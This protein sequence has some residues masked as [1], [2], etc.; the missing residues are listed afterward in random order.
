MLRKLLF[1]GLLATAALPAVASTLNYAFRAVP[2]RTGIVLV[3]S[4]QSGAP[5]NFANDA[6]HVFY[7]LDSNR[8]IKPGGWSFYN[9]GAPSRV[10]LEI[11]NRW[12]A[13]SGILLPIDEVITK[14]SAPY[15][16]LNL[17]QAGEAQMSNYDLLLVPAYRYVSLNSLEREKLRRFVE[18]GG[19]LWVDLASGSGLTVDVLNGFPLPFNASTTNLGLANSYEFLHP[20]FNRPNT[21]TTADIYNMESEHLLGLRNVDLLALGLGDLREHHSAT[22]YDSNLFRAVAEDELGPQIGVAQIGEGY[23]IVTSRGLSRSINQVVDPA[24]GTFSSNL[25]PYGLKPNFSRSA[26]AAAKLV[27]NMVYLSSSYSQIG[28]G[29]RKTNSSILDLGAPML[30]SWDA[31]FATTPGSFNYIPPAIYKGRTYAVSNG[32]LFCLDSKP[33][34]DLDKDGN[35]DDGVLDFAFGAN[36]D[37]IWQQNIVGP[38]SPPTCAEV[39]GSGSPDQVSIID[40]TGRMVVFDAL[41]GANLATINPPAAAEVEPGLPGR[42][43]YSPTYHDG[44]YLISDQVNT[45]LSSVGRV[46]IVD[47]ATLAPLTSTGPW[48]CGG[49]SSQIMGKPT[50]SPTVG[51]IPV[52]D[53][54]GALD[55][56]VYVPTRPAAFGG[57]NANAAVHSLWLGVKG[58]KPYSWVVNAGNLFVVTR[59]SLNGLSVYKPSGPSP[60][61]MKLTI[62]DNN[63]NPLTPAQMD[64]LFTSAVTE[65]AGLLTFAMEVGQTI[66]ANYSIRIDYSIDWGKGTPGLGAQILRGQLFMPDDTR[67]RRRI[68][69]NVALAPDGMIHVVHSDP[70]ISNPSQN[71]GGCYYAFQ[72][73]KR[74]EFKMRSRFELYREHSFT[75]NQVGSTT[76]QE[77][78]RDTDPLTQIIPFLGGR[79]QYLRF[80]GPPTIHNGVAYVPAAGQKGFIPN[81]ILCAFRATPPIPEVVVGDINGSFSVLQPDLARSDIKNAPSIYSQFSNSNF[82][83]ERTTGGSSGVLRFDNLMNVPRGFIGNSLSLSQPIILRRNGQPDLLVE[84]SKS[85]D[86]WSPLLWYS[87]FHGWDGDDGAG[88]VLCTGDT[89]FLSGKS[90]L[91]YFVSVVGPPTFPPPTNGLLTAMAAEIAPNDSFLLPDPQR[92]WQK[93]VSHLKITGS[94]PGPN[95]DISGNPAIRWPQFAGMKNFDDFRVRLLQTVLGP[96]TASFGVVGGDNVL[97]SWSELGVWAFSKA[98]YLICDEG[99]LARFDGSGNPIWTADAAIKSSQETNIGT[100]GETKPLV[101]PTR[102]YVLSDREMIVCDTGANRVVR[103]DIGGRELRS[104]SGFNLDMVFRPDG[105]VDGESSKLREP[106]DVLTFTT[107]ENNPTQLNNPQARE[108]WI[109]YIIA[110]SGNKRL[111]EMIDRYRVNAVTGRIEGLITQTDGSPAS[112]ILWWHSPSSL[113]GK[114]FDYNGL[115]RTFVESQ[116]NPGTGTWVYAAGIGSTMPTRVD[117]GLDSPTNALPREASEGN[118]GIVVFDAN[119]TQVVNEVTVQGIGANVYYDPPLLAFN[120]AATYTRIKKL[121]NLSSVTMRNI[122]DITFGNRVAIMFTDSEGVWEIIQPAANGP[123]IV[124]WMLPREAYRVLRRTGTFVS[125]TNALDMR[126]TYAK[127]LDSGEVLVV[128]GYVGRTL[129]GLDFKGEVVTV[130]GDFDIT[131]NNNLPGFSFT[132]NN[133]GFSSISVKAELP[134][135]QGARGL[136]VPVFA[137]RR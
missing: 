25:G 13:L 89:L 110:D 117:L 122:V 72:E 78:F 100:S 133:F 37:L 2:I 90:A 18:G 58:E 26:D 87:V 4:Q 124:R 114:Q 125:N 120:S 106:R 53:G 21:I 28:R 27:M 22:E 81:T 88:P 98:D 83:Y 101:R 105:Y 119:S 76:Y 136:V 7:N 24:T 42:G 111:L 33:S 66:P 52:S 20:I 71:T 45:G 130:D 16:E 77:T 31:R 19:T 41:T 85:G 116:A 118:G 51:Y 35:P 73:E 47:G 6:P 131:N 48:L 113:S 14:K 12:L 60:V 112:S 9:P 40:S 94:F 104:I 91:P 108:Y 10:T 129:A 50:S 99:R 34:S 135:I 74:G 79:F 57:P 96:S 55:R 29:S 109:H 97:A 103:L 32:V 68:L 102:A 3:A 54:S 123:W 30:K 63:G 36:V 80:I 134:P 59:A 115:A 11:Q 82:T 38:T 92:T 107:Y 17:A 86:R 93:Q 8:N 56:V 43:P 132:K 128:S 1:S 62:I 61:G 49:F 121:G 5:L 75:L 67:R 64:I 70:D 46:W 15:W 23:M 44:L 137:D 69:G 84:P 126:A 39:P 95:P 65:T 127:R